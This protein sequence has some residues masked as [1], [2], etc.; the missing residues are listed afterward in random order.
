[1]GMYDISAKARCPYYRSEQRGESARIRCDGIAPGSWLHVGFDDPQAMLQW[2]D[3]LCKC[4]WQAC[5][6]AKI[7]R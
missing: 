6:I 3:R 5:P 2:R 4:D 7:R 1:M